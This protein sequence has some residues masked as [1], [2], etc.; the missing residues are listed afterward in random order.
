MSSQ[1]S[2]IEAPILEF[3]TNDLLRGEEEI[4][5]DTPLLALGIIDSL[6]MVSILSFIQRHF[7]VDIPNDSITVDNFEDVTAIAKIIRQRLELDS[8][9]N[10]AVGGSEASPMEQAVAAIKARGVRSARYSLGND[11]ESHTLS[12]EGNPNVPWIMVP[13]LGNPASAYGNL[14]TTVRGQHTALAVDLVGFGLSTG[15]EAPTFRDHA[16]H[17]ERLLEVRFARQ[18]VLVMGS[19]AG[20]L[21]ALELARRAPKIVA[22]LVLMGFGLVD[23]P[24]AWKAELDELW[25]N[26]QAFRIPPGPSDPFGELLATARARPA[27]D[28]FCTAEDYGPKALKGISVP[29]LVVGGKEDRIVSSEATRA[30]ASAIP[31]S[32]LVELGGAGHFPERERPQDVINAVDSFLRERGIFS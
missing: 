9:G 28:S 17:L 10:K 8:G 24:V 6:S 27:F 20:A 16:S 3:I 2:E 18:R 32:K 22:A 23:D 15:L 26:P 21:V 7:H 29:V 13:G 19:S 11:I 25:S 4:E 5:T 12:V 30:M 31:G 14:L 1:T